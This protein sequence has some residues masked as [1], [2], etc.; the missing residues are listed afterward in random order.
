MRKNWAPAGTGHD[1][2][3]QTRLITKGPF[4]YSRNPIY[5]G[6]ILM[7]VGLLVSVR[8]YLLPLSLVQII[9]FY[10]SILKEEKLLERYFGKDYINYKSKVPRFI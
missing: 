8:S 3:K 6:L 9:F 7:T 10:K 4:Q 2:S 5:V 1:I